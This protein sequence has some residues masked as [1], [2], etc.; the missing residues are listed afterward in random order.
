[1]QKNA[2]SLA[3]IGAD[4]AENEQH[5]AESLTKFRDVTAWSASYFSELSLS[6]IGSGSD[7]AGTDDDGS[8]VFPL[9]N[10]DPGFAGTQS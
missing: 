3:K 2:Y 7:S 5:I 9:R 8:H 1:M 6:A 10:L 4:P